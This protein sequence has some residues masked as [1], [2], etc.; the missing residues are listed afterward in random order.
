MG[1]AFGFLCLRGFISFEDVPLLNLG[2]PEASG[3]LAPPKAKTSLSRWGAACAVLFL[4]GGSR[5]WGSVNSLL[6]QGYAAY[7]HGQYAKAEDFYL[8]A[9]RKDPRNAGTLYAAGV[10]EYQQKNFPQ[11]ESYLR[12][13]LS[14]KPA[15]RVARALLDRVEQLLAAR[16]V[17]DLQFGGEKARESV[18]TLLRQGYNAYIQN[19]FAQ[20]EDCY[21]QVLRQ[22]PQNAGALYAAGVCEYRKKNYSESQ[23]YLRKSY[24][25]KAPFPQVRVLLKRVDRLLAAQEVQDL[26]FIL[27]MEE[28]VLYYRSHQYDKALSVLEKAA[29]LNPESGDLHFNLGL[30]YMKLKQWDKSLGELEK[31]L[32]LKPGDARAQYALGV[33]FQKVGAMAQAQLYFLSLAESPNSGLYNW[34]AMQRLSTLHSDTSN[35]P[36]HLS[37]RLQGGGGESALDQTAPGPVPLASGGINQYDHLQLSYTPLWWK[38]PFNFSYGGDLIWYKAPGQS[39]SYSDLHDFSAGAQVRLPANWTVPLSFDEQVGFNPAGDLYYQHHQVSAAFLWLFQGPNSINFQFQYMREMYPAPIGL[40]TNNWTGTTS[41]SLVLGGAHFLNLA[42]SFR[43]STA[44][45]AATDYFNYYLNSLS[46]AY[47]VELGRGFNLTLN[48]TPQWQVYPFFNDGIGLNDS[49]SVSRSDWIQNLNAEFAVPLSGHW[50]FVLGD[51][52]QVLQSSIAAYSLR[53]NNYYAATQI[54]F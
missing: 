5:A 21:Q 45:T 47:H 44:D 35:S 49:N 4:L 7:S 22:D 3:R 50:N 1:R 36:F 37:L 2:I 48:Y 24:A 11:A 31:C 8:Q 38:T 43:Q 12:R 26:Q 13:A 27:M 53:S 28:G 34:A 40:T 15:F 54:F 46:L 30:T 6:R 10:C 23:S 52:Y 17:P 39:P 18:D 51:Q 16:K 19:H 42:Y 33:L 25:L 9:F 14:L 41:C 32:K 20:A 29:A